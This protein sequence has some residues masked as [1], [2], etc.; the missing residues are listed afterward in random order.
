MLGIINFMDFVLHLIVKDTTELIKHYVL[1]RV[2]S[3]KC[4]VFIWF[5]LSLKRSDDGWVRVCVLF[6]RGGDGWIRMYVLLLKSADGWV[7]MCVLF[8]KGADGWV[9]M[10]VLFFKS[11]DGWVR[12][13]LFCFSKV[14]MDEWGCL[15]C[16]SKVL[17]DEWG[18][19]FCFSKVLVDDW[20][21][22][23][24]F[25]KVLMDE[26]GCVLFFKGADGSVRMFDLRH[27]EH[28]TIIYEDPQHTPLLR[29]AWN[30][31]DP[32][33]LATVAMDACE[34]SSYCEYLIGAFWRLKIPV[35]VSL[36][37]F[38][39]LFFFLS[40]LILSSFSSLLY[41]PSLPPSGG[42]GGSGVRDWRY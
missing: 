2:Q 22:L 13:F 26:W 1:G 41:S 40:F 36:L 39:R 18:C 12:M 23:F 19:L 16:F 5:L 37:N 6:F 9:R 33:Y 15:F 34:V 24:C 14:L 11:A 4:N 10:F 8:F 20:G 27:L 32:N 17:M 38:G 35:L 31:Q 28:S 29:L 21:F 30:K 42:G 25:S 3:P 7:R